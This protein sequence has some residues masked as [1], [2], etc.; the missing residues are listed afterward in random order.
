M[1]F[2]SVACVGIS[3]DYKS[4]RQFLKIFDHHLPL[5]ISFVSFLF[6][7]MNTIKIENSLKIS[8]YFRFN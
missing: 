8:L 3:L 2:L 5:T 7:F 4:N 1:V 6:F